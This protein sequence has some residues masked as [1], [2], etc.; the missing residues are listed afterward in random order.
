LG[1][2]EWNPLALGTALAMW[3]DCGFGLTLN[4]SNVAAWADRS[5][6]GRNGVQG[7]GAQQPPTVFDTALHRTVLSFDGARQF[8][9]LTWPSDGSCSA[10]AVLNPTTTGTYHNIFETN[11]V[12]RSP[13]LWIQPDGDLE[14]NTSL[15]PILPA[16]SG[17]RVV[18]MRS[19][20]TAPR[21][22]AVQNGGTP[23]TT[24]YASVIAPTA[25]TTFF[26]R[27]G[28]SRYQGRFAELLY[29][30]RVLTDAETAQTMAY[31]RKK[32]GGIW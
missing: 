10:F 15:G 30:Q 28:G 29:F 14:V 26:N 24:S 25:T 22:E 16:S 32:Y 23:V 12:D 6:N 20:P 13:Q 11:S 18:G 31:L 9:S 4:G 27:G 8:N 17:W 21:N 7:T 19:R 1:Y 5:G 3:W 2:G